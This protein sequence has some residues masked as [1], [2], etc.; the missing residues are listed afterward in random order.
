MSESARKRGRLSRSGDFDRV[1]REG[2]S[3]AN[4]FLVL[5]SFPRQASG[6]PRLGLSVGRKVGGAVVRNK[7]KRRLREA[8][9]SIAESSQE[10]PPDHDFVVVA[11]PGVEELV[12]R[13]GTPGLERSLAGLLADGP[14][15]EQPASPPSGGT[16]GEAEEPPPDSERLT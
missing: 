11:R 3:R 12:D 1:Y 16:G 13:E 14:E 7:V 4:R 15:E 6:Q 9:W 5:Y 8:F 10:L 2:E